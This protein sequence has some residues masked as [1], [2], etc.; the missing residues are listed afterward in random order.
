MTLDEL[1]R[2]VHLMLA[3]ARARGIDKIAFDDDLYWTVTSPEWL[4][5]Y[6]EPTPAVGSLDDDREE[7]NRLLSDP[8]RASSV[9]LERLSHV[10]RYLSDQLSMGTRDS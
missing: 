2:C 9:D 5:P 6:S 4:K 10:L 7:L 3:Y 1:E 8:S